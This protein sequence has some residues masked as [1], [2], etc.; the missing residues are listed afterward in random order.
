MVKRLRFSIIGLLVLTLIVALAAS[1]VVTYRRLREVE[2]AL[3]KLR[4]DVGELTVSNPNLLHAKSIPSFE[5]STYRWRL[6][7]PE[8]RGFNIRA[9]AGQ[10]PEQGLPRSGSAKNLVERSYAPQT[11]DSEMIETVAVTRNQK[12][13]WQLTLDDGDTSSIAPLPENLNPWLEKSSGRAWNVAGRKETAAASKGEP[14]YLLRMR[15]AKEMPGGIS[16]IDM[17]PTDG[18]LVWIE[19]TP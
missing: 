16:T 2:P 13:R 11:S 1:N 17:Q 19:E 10:I 12:G 9:V 14:L 7:L 3:E 8:D 6:H 5:D 18:I 4:N 15:K